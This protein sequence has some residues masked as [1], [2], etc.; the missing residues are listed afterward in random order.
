MA[1]VRTT[2]LAATLWV[3][4]F[5]HDDDPSVVGSQT[6]TEEME[7]HNSC[8]LSRELSLGVYAGAGQSDLKFSTPEK[9]LIIA[10]CKPKNIQEWTDWDFRDVSTINIL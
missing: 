2:P 4:T 7:Q 1:A 8:T 6:N 5:K 10:K 9:I 3:Y